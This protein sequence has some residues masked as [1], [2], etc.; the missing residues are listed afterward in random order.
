MGW[1]ITDRLDEYA[2]AALP[3]LRERPVLHNVSLTVLETL[4]AGRVYPEPP[5]FGWWT[6]RNGAVGGAFSHTPPFTLLLATVPDEALEP[7]AEAL[8][9]W[10]RPLAGVHGTRR[11]APLFADAWARRTGCGARVS[12]EQRLYALG[13]LTTP[14]P[15]PPGRARQASDADTDLLTEWTRRFNRDAGM[16]DANTPEVVQDKLGYGGWFLWEAAGVPVAL[17]GLTRPG[18]GVIRVGPVFTPEEHRRLGYGSAVTAAASRAA[19]DRA[20]DA[21]VLFTDLANPT[22]NSIYQRLGYRAVEDRLILLFDG[23]DVIGR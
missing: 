16:P 4:R 1:R 22:S 19:L 5:L 12:L 8:V 9:G 20:A 3:F 10:G 18:G 21:V 17:A 23:S 14:D 15:A 6:D 11:T 2:A 7:L 13:S